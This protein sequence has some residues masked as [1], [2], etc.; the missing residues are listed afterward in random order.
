MHYDDDAILDGFGT[1][2]DAFAADMAD[3]DHETI[4]ATTA[5]GAFRVS[6]DATADEPFAV[7]RY[8]SF[9]AALTCSDGSASVDGAFLD[10]AA[11]VIAW[12][13]ERTPVTTPDDPCAQCAL[14]TARETE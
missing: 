14:E 11:A 6:V 1:I 8:G 5:G 2:A 4:I 12:I 13:N 10:D 3:V 7:N 9:E